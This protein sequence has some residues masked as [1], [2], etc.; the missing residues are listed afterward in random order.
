MTS[1]RGFMD[2]TV[3]IHHLY[4]KDGKISLSELRHSIAEHDGFNSVESYNE[5]FEDHRKIPK[6]GKE[7]M[8]IIIKNHGDDGRFAAFVKKKEDE[9]LSEFVKKMPTIKIDDCVGSIEYD[10]K[11]KY[12][13]IKMVLSSEDI[14]KYGIDGHER[15]GFNLFGQSFDFAD[16][17]QITQIE[18]DNIIGYVF[19]CR[20]DDDQDSNDY[21]Y[22]EII[23][24]VANN[25]TMQ[26]KAFN[27]V[28]HFSLHECR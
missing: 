19:S 1:S 21:I 6:I 8:D 7:A 11:N 4:R 22:Q 15:F 16:C 14:A 28:F 26:F 25:E 18:S 24:F 27:K 23:N 10:V 12:F 3:M 2:L 13:L 20:F 17:A 5:S 9:N